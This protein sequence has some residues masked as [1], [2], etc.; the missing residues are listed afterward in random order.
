MAEGGWSPRVLEGLTPAPTSGGL[1]PSPLSPFG[2]KS[3]EDQPLFRVRPDHAI[4]SEPVPVDTVMGIGLGRLSPSMQFPR[5]PGG[6]GRA[7]RNVRLACHSGGPFSTSRRPDHNCALSNR[8]G[9]RAAVRSL[10]GSIRRPRL[11]A[12]LGGSLTGVGIR[13]RFHRTPGL[14][15]ALSHDSAQCSTYGASCWDGAHPS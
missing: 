4:D 1:P 8:G 14:P 10:G 12:G 9:V 11:P 13:H 3:D 6:S 5:R 7:S 2:L 15:A